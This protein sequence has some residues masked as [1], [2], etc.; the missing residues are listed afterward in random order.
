MYMCHKDCSFLAF[1]IPELGI[2]DTFKEEHEN[3]KQCLTERYSPFLE[4]NG[5]VPYEW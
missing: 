2:P 4:E 3:E 1:V 5:I